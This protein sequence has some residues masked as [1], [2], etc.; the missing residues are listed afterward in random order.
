MSRAQALWRPMLAADLDRVMEIA[1]VVHQ[2]FPERRE[3]MAQRQQVFPAGC[4]MWQRAGEQAEGYALTHPG[5]WR[6][7]PALDCLLGDLPAAEEQE[8]CYY[9]H[10]IALLP[11]ARGGGAGSALMGALVA[12][13]RRFGYQRMAL[14]A[15]HGSVPFWQKQGFAIESANAELAA[16]LAT[17]D[18]TAQYMSQ[19]L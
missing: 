9:L 19:S 6:R 18:A 15:V 2:D 13:A 8:A 17:Y 12:V 3:V 5:W 1:D 4:W 10:D 16:K 14:V 11:S 7:P